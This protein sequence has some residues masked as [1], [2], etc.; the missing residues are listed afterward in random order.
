[1]IH[2][3]S[4]R[5]A[6]GGAL[7]LAAMESAGSVAHPVLYERKAYSSSS[8]NARLLLIQNMSGMS[9]LDGADDLKMEDWSFVLQDIC[10]RSGVARFG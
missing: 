6:L 2:C 10:W 7:A 5:S 9:E 3:A 8:S 1:L 4:S